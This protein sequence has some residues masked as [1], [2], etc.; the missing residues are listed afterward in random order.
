MKIAL[1]TRKIENEPINGFERYAHNLRDGLT[2]QGADLLLLNQDSP[3]P[4]RPTGSL[5]S[6]PYYDVALPILRLME[7]RAK[8]DV[9]H[10]L[11]DSQ[12]VLFPF[13]KG[14]KVVTIH[15]MD[16]TPPGAP[17][18]AL[19]RRFYGLGTEIAVRYADHFICI[20][21]QT[22][23]ELTERYPIP[24]EKISV[25]HRSISPVF[26]PLEKRGRTIGYLGALRKRKNV[27]FT[28]RAYA[29]FQQ[30]HPDPGCKL[31][32]CGDGPDEPRLKGLVREAGLD[33][34][35]EFRGQIPADKLMETYNSFTLF[36]FPSLQEGFG[37]STL[38]A[39]ACGVPV[40]V[41]KGAMVPEEVTR[42]AVP[43]V[44]EEDMAEQFHRLLSDDA[45]RE[46]VIRSGL[47]FAAGF[48]IEAEAR[49][50]MKVYEKVCGQAR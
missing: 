36:A 50:T 16:K 48:S 25:V 14:Q 42:Q 23:D 3:L 2:A 21:E 8:A 49:K 34:L 46:R 35:V 5:I 32:I 38:E 19:F 41:L 26:R 37:L 18:E 9:F 28:I 11:T 29:L 7:G 1:L 15:H 30:R 31:L 10:A 17:S 27:E 45:L 12:A 6:P 47:E 44:D 39:Q 33:R 4:V 20:S 43:C 13:L 22:K 40:L 24:E